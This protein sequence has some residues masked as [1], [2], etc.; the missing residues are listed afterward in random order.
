MWPLGMSSF[1]LGLPHL[2]HGLGKHPVASDKSSVQDEA[3]ERALGFTRHSLVAPE[4]PEP[5]TQHHESHHHSPNVP[6]AGCHVATRC[7]QQEQ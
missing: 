2:P 3:E 7:G 5:E 6:A 4:R 1:S